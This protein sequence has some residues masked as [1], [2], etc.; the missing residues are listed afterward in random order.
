MADVERI[1]AYLQQY[2]EAGGMYKL[3]AVD[4]AR[5]L[6]RAG[7]LSDSKS[8]PG[9]PLREL[10]RRGRIRGAAQ[11]ANGRWFIRR[12]SPAASDFGVPTAPALQ[13]AST[14][15]QPCPVGRSAPILPDVLPPGLAVVFVGESAGQTSAREGNYYAGHR[16]CFWA[17]L[18]TAGITSRQFHPSE[19]AL[20]PEFGVGLTDVFKHVSNAELKRMSP[21]ARA[22]AVRAGADAL[23]RRLAV[24]SPVAVCFMGLGLGREVG[25]YLFGWEEGSSRGA[26]QQPDALLGDCQV[27]LCP[28][29][30]AAA[31]ASVALVRT[32]LSD[33]F[34]QV[35]RPWQERNRRGT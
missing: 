26:G 21:A 14:A 8:R 13:A 34:A 20:L 28:S 23:R 24:A 7:L 18:A 2:L 3:S 22:A 31:R 10:L 5:V 16:N 32:V 27:W 11:E 6:D 30:S 4:A 12:A 17:E 15:G 9:R 35:V 1:N 33:L 25:V 19:W 29:T